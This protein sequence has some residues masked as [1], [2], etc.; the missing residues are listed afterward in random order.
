MYLPNL[1][2][3]A[4]P[5]NEII[6]IG[7]LR[8]GCEPPISEKEGVWNGTV[9]KSVGDFLQALYLYAFQRYFAFALQHATFLHPP[10]VSPKIS[11]CSPGSRWMAFGLRR[12][13]VLG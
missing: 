7:I 4:L 5:V 3:V 12:A 8:V 6:A 11:P 1:K 13:K 9:R 2:S 10:L